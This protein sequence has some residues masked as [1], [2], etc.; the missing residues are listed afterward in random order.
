MAEK[1]EE[2]IITLRAADALISAHDG[3]MA[4]L[5]LYMARHPHCSMDEAAAALSMTMA[6][7]SAA[8]EKL[9][10]IGA[11]GDE[12]VRRSAVYPP[13]DDEETQY[14]TE[15]I[16]RLFESD[17]GFGAVREE[18]SRIL[19]TLPSRAHLNALAD[20]YNRCALPPDVLMELI[21]FCDEENRRRYSGSRPLGAKTI[22]LE[23]AKW[24]SLEI[25]TAERA[26]EYMEK[27]RSSLRLEAKIAAAV[28]I[29]GRPLGLTEAKYID[30]WI[31][32]GFDEAAVSIAYD[33][34]LTNTGALK[35]PYINSIILKW[36]R[37]GLHTVKDIEEKD[38]RRPVH[39]GTAG[40]QTSDGIDLDDLKRT[41][42]E[43]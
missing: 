33:R 28:G 4:L 21:N 2:K 29:S 35:W 20:A 41:L 13:A 23:A 12:G 42:G 25:V 40:M 14:S 7:V 31:E 38:T 19:G 11:S 24:A 5:Y 17:A 8:K 15:D 16:K 22:S 34:T 30:S 37:S 27:R 26:E 10:R 36:H 43:I 3:N 18:L 6:E 32:M 1:N 39:S 9:T